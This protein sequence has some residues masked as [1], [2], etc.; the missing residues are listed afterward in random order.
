MEITIDNDGQQVSVE[1]SVEVGVFLDEAK[2]ADESAARKRR[3]HLDDR[4]FT[5]YIAAT[6]GRLLSQE[7]PEEAICRRETQDELQ[8]V[9]AA[10]TVEQRKRFLLYALYGHSY[11]EVGKLCGCSKYAAR[12]SIKAVKKI[13]RNV[14]SNDP[15]I[16][17]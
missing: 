8:S 6:E 7:S 5:E 13:F 17:L 11:A 16:G 15:T 3:R 4:E 1:I 9:L 2:R 10:C 12:D 14:L